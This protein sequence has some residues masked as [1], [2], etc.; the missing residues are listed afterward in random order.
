MSRLLLALVIMAVS[1]PFAAADNTGFLYGTITLHK[2][3]QHTGFLRWDREE[4]YWDDLFH[5]RQVDAAFFEHIDMKVLHDE[6]KKKYFA[7]HGLFDRLMW[8]MNNREDGD[9]PTRLFICRFGDMAAITLDED[10]NV[11]IHMNDGR[12]VGVRGYANDVRSDILIYTGEEE[13]VEIDWDDMVR[14]EFAQTPP[15]AVPYATRARGSVKARSGETEGFIMWDESECTSIDVLDSDQKDVPLGDVQRISR[16]REGGSDVTLTDGT[17]LHLTGSNDVGKGQRG[18]HVE[19]LGVGRVNVPWKDFLE[20]DFDHCAG[21]GAGRD[22]YPAIQE[23]HGAVTDIDGN[24]RDGIMV[25]DA[26]EAYTCDIFNGVGDPWEYDIP[27]GNIS[28]ISKTGES[29]CRVTLV[30]GQI[31]ELSGHQDT[32]QQNAGVLVWSE[33]GADPV[34]IPW[35]RFQE[36]V[37]TP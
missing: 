37:F 11:T 32:G 25:W 29:S 7:E 4:A 3:E 18:T 20:V 8:T 30:T 14:I 22:A 17:N 23:L 6:R 28:A 21:S 27:F 34:H 24:I 9:E 26:D 16:A 33:E 2:G 10:E 35:S 31:L 12:E 13:P 19:V 1:A 15:E 36:I 5:S